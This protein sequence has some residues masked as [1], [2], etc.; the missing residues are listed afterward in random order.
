MSG[1]VRG[2]GVEADLTGVLALYRTMQAVSRY[3][4]LIM[5][6][7]TLPQAARKVLL[8]AGLQ[9]REVPHLIPAAGQHP[10]FDPKFLRLNDAWT[11]LQ[12]WSLTEYDRV[13]LIDSDMIFLRGMDELFDLELPGKDWIAG[14]PACICNPLKFAHYPKDWRVV[15]LPLD[16]TIDLQDARQLRIDA[17]ATSHASPRPTHTCRRWTADFSPAQ[18][19]HGRAQPVRP[20]DER[21]QTLP[22]HLSYRRRSQSRRS[23]RD[24]RVLQGKMA[25]VSLVGQR[26]Q[27]PAGHP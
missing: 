23:G 2:P 25:A 24:R 18:L 13:V 12:V 6:T 7:D 11:K 19:W 10:G 9:I 21:N 1:A 20:D 22:R 26:A 17:P 5:T 15:H 14:A 27:A 3:P 16:P 4:L 8:D